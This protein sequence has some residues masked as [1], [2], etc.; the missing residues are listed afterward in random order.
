MDGWTLLFDLREALH[1]RADS[2]WLSDQSSY[3]YLYEAAKELNSRSAVITS[4]QSITTVADTAEY[5]LNPDF[6]GLYLRDDD[7][8][9]YV[10]LNDGTNDHFIIDKSYEDI[11]YDNLTTSQ[12][13]PNYFAVKHATSQV[14]NVTGTASAGG[15]VSNGEAT[16]TDTS[17]STKFSTISAGDLVH[18]TTQGYHGI[19]LEKSSDTAL[20]TAI[21]DSA[22]DASS[23]TTSDAYVIVPQPRYSIIFE[24]PFETAGYTLTV[25]YIQSPAPVFAPYRSYKFPIEAKRVLIE[26][27]VA[28]YKYRDRDPSEAAVHLGMFDRTLRMA[29]SETNRAKIRNRFYM[30]MKRRKR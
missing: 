24:P 23:W 29:G 1:E 15:T 9:Y 20:I 17:S 27:S 25:S 4:T 8:N 3:T 11:V 2:D 30:N 28:R 21:F 7:N 18:N 13:V 22:G 12:N 5:N 10:K 6:M 19:A 14:S 26:Y 16:L